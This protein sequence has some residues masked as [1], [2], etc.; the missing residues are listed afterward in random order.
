[1]LTKKE[2]WRIIEKDR[3]K[4]GMTRREYSR[5]LGLPPGYLQS[6]KGTPFLPVPEKMLAFIGLIDNDTI[7]EQCLSFDM[8]TTHADDIL[9]ELEVS[10]ECKQRIRLKRKMKRGAL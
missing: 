5:S 1:M 4:K 6:L 9:A 2:F 3:K 8:V 10:K 7:Y